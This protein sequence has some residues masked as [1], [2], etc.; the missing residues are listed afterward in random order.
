MFASASKVSFQKHALVLGL[1]HRRQ[2]QQNGSTSKESIL[3][4]LLPEAL[5]R[6][7]DLHGPHDFAQVFTFATNDPRVL[8]TEDMRDHLQN[9]LHEHLSPFVGRLHQDSTAQ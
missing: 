1:T 2:Q 9:M 7:L 5:I 3:T 6:I 4:T 8:W